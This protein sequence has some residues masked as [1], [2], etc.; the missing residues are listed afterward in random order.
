MPLSRML[1]DKINSQKDE[2]IDIVRKIRMKNDIEDDEDL[3]IELFDKI[4]SEC[5][6]IICFDT[7]D[8]YI[9]QYNGREEDYV[10]D[11]CTVHSRELT[12]ITDERKA[13]HTF[14]WALQHFI[15]SSDYQKNDLIQVMATIHAAVYRDC[16]Q[17]LAYSLHRHLSFPLVQ[18]CCPSQMLD[19]HQILPMKCSS[20][21]PTVQLIDNGEN[22]MSV[23]HL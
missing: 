14:M 3:P 1:M 4:V 2:F 9:I 19:T 23:K 16:L 22:L 10:H 7:S 15:Q 17:I 6:D 12:S 11:F 18:G 20:P 5:T 21:L 8:I 13:R